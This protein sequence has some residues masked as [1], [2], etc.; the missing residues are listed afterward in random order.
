MLYFQ[1]GTEEKWKQI[2][3]LNVLSLSICIKEAIQIMKEK[4]EDDGHII[5]INRYH[6]IVW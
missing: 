5:N 1:D 2:F 6:S 3:N 4:G